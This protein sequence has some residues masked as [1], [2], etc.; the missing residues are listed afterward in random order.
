MYVSIES[1]VNI[2]VYNF[3]V[4]DDIAPLREFYMILLHFYQYL[5]LK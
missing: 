3:F 1:H 4:E 5:D 2:F